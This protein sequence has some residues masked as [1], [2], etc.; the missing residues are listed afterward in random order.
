M[1]ENRGRLGWR[2][3]SGGGGRGWGGWGDGVGGGYF[4]IFLES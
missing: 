4:R 3:G 2:G 1:N